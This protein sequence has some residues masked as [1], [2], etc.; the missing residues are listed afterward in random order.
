VVTVQDPREGVAVYM[1]VI[2]IV[3]DTDML[4]LATPAASFQMSP[5]PITHHVHSLPVFSVYVNIF[6]NCKKGGCM[7][8]GSMQFGMTKDESNKIKI[9][10]IY[11]FVCRQFAEKYHH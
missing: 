10:R 3:L 2:Q 7:Y 5:I 8:V 1:Q 11:I 6:C 4:F 9:S